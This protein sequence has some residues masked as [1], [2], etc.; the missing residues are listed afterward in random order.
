MKM[1]NLLVV[2]TARCGL[3]V[4]MQMLHAGGYP[5]HGEY[6]GFEPYKYGEYHWD[7]MPQDGGAIKIPDAH[8]QNIPQDRDFRVICLRRLRVAEQIKSMNKW[9]LALWGLPPMNTPRLQAALMND[10]QRISELVGRWPTLWL[11]FEQIINDTASTV[12]SIA[13]FVGTELVELDVSAM[14]GAVRPRSTDCYPGLLEAE[15]I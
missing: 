13:D 4:T 9:N 2:G 7:S 6:P 11:S 3:T 15:M 12:Q 8:R 1:R 10:N 14:Q 5:C